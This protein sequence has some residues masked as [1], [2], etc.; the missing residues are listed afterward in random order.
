[1]ELAKR[2]T[3]DSRSAS[4][5]SLVY[6]SLKS[7]M[8]LLVSRTIASR[9]ARGAS[10]QFH[11]I[12]P[13]NEIDRGLSLGHRAQ[14]ARIVVQHRHF[15]KESPSAAREMGRASPCATT[16]FRVTMPSFTT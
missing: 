9:Q 10:Q 16:L 14:R 12:R 7:R 8:R 11:Q 2:P 3:S 15:T 6:F 4:S 5:T 13:G 1:M